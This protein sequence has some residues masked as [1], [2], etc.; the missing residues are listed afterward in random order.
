MNYDLKN[1]KFL[2]DKIKKLYPQFVMPDEFDVECWTEVL[3][4]HT[5]PEILEAL[6]EYR[7][8]TEYNVAPNPAGLKKYLTKTSVV[9]PDSDEDLKRRC[10]KCMW[11]MHDKFG[12]EGAQ[13]YWRALLNTYG[14]PYPATEE[15]MRGL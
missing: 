14:I 3:E 10:I 1:T 2:F 4:G 8:N 9:I 12:L 15:I 6:K 11:N 5:Q 7:K 13:S